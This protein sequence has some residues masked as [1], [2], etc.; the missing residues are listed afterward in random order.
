MKEREGRK[1]HRGGQV[2]VLGN[3]DMNYKCLEGEQ[4]WKECSRL[5]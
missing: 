5:V 3:V 1:G 2:G 4:V